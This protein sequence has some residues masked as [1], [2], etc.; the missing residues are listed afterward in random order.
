MKEITLESVKWKMHI[1]VK[2]MA[3]LEFLILTKNN[4]KKQCL[5]KDNFEL[6]KMSRYT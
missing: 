4:K 5:E 6:L 1:K 2:K 3:P